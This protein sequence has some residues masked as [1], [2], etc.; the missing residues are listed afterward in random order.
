MPALMAPYE[1]LMNFDFLFIVTYGRSGSTLLQGIVNTIPGVL[2][3]GE[4]A[5]ALHGLIKSWEAVKIAQDLFSAD[6]EK[7]T[8]P[9][10]GAAGMD[11]DRFGHDLAA[12]FI[13]NILKPPPDIRVT[14]FKEIRYHLTAGELAFELEFM[15]RF[16]PRCAFLINTR[17]LEATIA[18]NKKA[19][20]D[21]SK[22]DLTKADQLLRDIAESSTRDIFHV[23]Y[24]DY[25]YDPDRLRPLFDFLGVNFDRVTLQNVFDTKHSS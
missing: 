1:V 24:D 10:F 4:N 8:S 6:S 20:H 14:G 23:H 7:P 15:R 21:V 16:F 3:R 25:R 18:S 9:W 11:L 2:I 17:G 19:G 13:R 12:S 5:G 22:E